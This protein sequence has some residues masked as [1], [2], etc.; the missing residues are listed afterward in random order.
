M[1][2]HFF[3]FCK[4][5]I[6]AIAFKALFYF[7]SVEIS[8]FLLIRKPVVFKKY[9]KTDIVMSKFVSLQ[10]YFDLTLQLPVKRLKTTF[11]SFRKLLYPHTGTLRLYWGTGTM[12]LGKTLND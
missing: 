11:L 9:V 8:K 6:V 12:F 10:C 2:H 4:Q 5:S 7:S 1:F 3:D